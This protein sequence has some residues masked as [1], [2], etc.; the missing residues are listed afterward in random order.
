MGRLTEQGTD[1]DCHLIIAVSLSSICEHIH[2]ASYPP[3][4][5]EERQ[6]VKGREKED[7]I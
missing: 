3:H 6:E 7:F 4:K 1:I 5:E 2:D